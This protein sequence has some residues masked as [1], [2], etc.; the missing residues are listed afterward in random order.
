MARTH[1]E[2]KMSSKKKVGVEV[3]NRRRFYLNLT[4]SGLK[5]IR[6]AYRIHRENL[7]KLFE[8]LNDNERTEFVRLLRKVGYHAEQIE[9]N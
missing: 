6:S 7:V 1:R 9:V 8:C 3:T 4:K 5:L 2:D